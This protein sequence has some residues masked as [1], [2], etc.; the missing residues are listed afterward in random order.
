MTGRAFCV[1]CTVIIMVFWSLL[2]YRRSIAEWGDTLR[3]AIQVKGVRSAK[4]DVGDGDVT[5]KV[6]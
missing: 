4:L 6:A 1:P 5:A 3:V 2:T